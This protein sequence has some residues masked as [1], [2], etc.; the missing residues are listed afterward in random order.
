MIALMRYATAYTPCRLACRLPASMLTIA[1]YGC[2]DVFAAMLIRRLLFCRRYAATDAVFYEAAFAFF[3]TRHTRAW[4]HDMLLPARHA[5]M[6]SMPPFFSLKNI[7]A[8]ML[9]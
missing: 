4:R 6:L 1:S 5:K 9:I 7:D 3:A 8:G 2:F